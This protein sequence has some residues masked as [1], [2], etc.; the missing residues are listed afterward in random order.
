MVLTG[1][2]FGIDAVIDL[3]LISS[4][5]MKYKNLIMTAVIP[6]FSFRC[7]FEINSATTH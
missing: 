1:E 7:N 4:H 6:S 5:E 3:S 2:V